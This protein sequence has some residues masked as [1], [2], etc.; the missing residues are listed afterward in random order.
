MNHVSISPTNENGSTQGQRK[1]LTRET[2]IAHLVRNK[3]IILKRNV[4]SSVS[5]SRDELFALVQ[6]S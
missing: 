4:F 2:K 3:I 6:G 5:A 1:N